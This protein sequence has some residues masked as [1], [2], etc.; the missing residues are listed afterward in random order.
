MEPL[1]TKLI[2]TAEAIPSDRAECRLARQSHSD[3]NQILTELSAQI[4]ARVGVDETAA[5]TSA[6]GHAVTISAV[7]A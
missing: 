4:A 7:V 5:A 6:K 1:K 2:A 3:K